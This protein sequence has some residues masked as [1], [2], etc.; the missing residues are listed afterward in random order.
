MLNRILRF[1]LVIVL[2][3]AGLIAVIPRAFPNT[4][5]VP[6][7]WD[8][9]GFTACDLPCY[10]GIEVG[11]TGFDQVAD[12][13][14]QH[15]D[16]LTQ[17]TLVVNQNIYFYATAGER[18]VVGSISFVRNQVTAFSLAAP[19]PLDL[20]LTAFGAPDCV[21]TI[22]NAVDDWW[23]WYLP[24]AVVVVQMGGSQLLQSAS[25]DFLT[26]VPPQEESS[27]DAELMTPWRGFAPSWVYKN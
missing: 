21:M 11:D 2:L 13:L 17:T 3:F 19:V 5:A 27:C 4:P 20:L 6:E 24:E 22:P 16:A 26:I 1:A 8:A 9:L 12:K 18:Q 15:I 14:E 10:A 7:Y 25:A 23:S